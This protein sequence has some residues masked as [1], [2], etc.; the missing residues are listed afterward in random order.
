MILWQGRR[1]YTD[2]NC[3]AGHMQFHVWTQ[4]CIHACTSMHAHIHINRQAGAQALDTTAS[5]CDKL[6]HPFLASGKMCELRHTQASKL[7]TVLATLNRLSMHYFQP[8]MSPDTLNLTDTGYQKQLK[9]HVHMHTCRGCCSS[10]KL[11]CPSWP[12][13]PRPQVYAQPFAPSAAQ[14]ASPAAI[15]STPTS[16]R[17]GT[18][19]GEG[20][21][22]RPGTPKTPCMPCSGI[23]SRMAVDKRG[24]K[25]VH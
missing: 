6:V 17:P 13:L 7:K 8:R 9:H 5:C 23:N 10:S 3:I 18:C 24:A 22:L 16:Q 1:C 2:N 21:L 4:P 11:P 12:Y 25:C 19:T 20:L 15:C 14:W